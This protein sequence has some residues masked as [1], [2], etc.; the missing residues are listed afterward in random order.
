[1]CILSK[2]SQVPTF[3]SSGQE[4]S[5]FPL[6]YIGLNNKNLQKRAAHICIL[7]QWILPYWHRYLYGG[8]S[9]PLQVLLNAGLC[10]VWLVREPLTKSYFYEK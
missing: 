9:N 1:M 3:Q 2:V 7:W 4:W 8:I 5:I 10:N 6:Q